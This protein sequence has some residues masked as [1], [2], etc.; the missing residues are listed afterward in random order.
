MAP[1]YIVS[2]AEDVD[3]GR[4]PSWDGKKREEAEKKRV[5]DKVECAETE[6]S[7]SCGVLKEF[8]GEQ[9]RGY[10]TLSLFIFGATEVSQIK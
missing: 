3:T 8:Q 1:P 5:D 2:L 7:P 6:N 9:C 4:A 10:G